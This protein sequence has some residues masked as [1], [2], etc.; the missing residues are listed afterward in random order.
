MGL[1]MM[2]ML[3]FY[4]LIFLFFIYCFNEIDFSSDT[5][6]KTNGVF[7]I[8]ATG[9]LFLYN[10]RFILENLVYNSNLFNIILF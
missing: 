1:W 9:L 6:K 2:D 8:G 7:E 3:K 4:L 5:D 10:L